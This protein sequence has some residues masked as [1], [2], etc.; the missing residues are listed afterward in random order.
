M[1][2][3]SPANTSEF[4]TEPV[5]QQKPTISAQKLMQRAGEQASDAGEYVTRN[6]QE[7]PF[8]AL[9][10]AGL[11]GYGIAFLIHTS[12]SS[13]E[14]RERTSAP[15]GHSGDVLQPLE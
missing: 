2:E 10:I 11:I 3:Y 5:K 8:A 1:S 6:V 13:R 15:E 4:T 7:Y 12:W 14:P 9:L